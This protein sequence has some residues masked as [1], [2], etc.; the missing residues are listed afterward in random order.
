MKKIVFMLVVTFMGILPHTLVAKQETSQSPEKPKLSAKQLKAMV[1]P[2]TKDQIKKGIN[3][4][5]RRKQPKGIPA[6]QFR[7]VKEINTYRFLCGVDSNMVIDPTLVTQA[8]AAALACKNAGKLSHGLGDY[9]DRCNLH[10]NTGPEAL[11]SQ[12]FNYMRDIGAHN[13]EK[14]GHRKHILDPVLMATGFSKNGHYAAMSVN[15]R[16]GTNTMTQGWGYPGRGYFPVKWFET[17]GWSYYPANG[18][19]C[20]K[21]QTTVKMW[22]LK[23]S[24]RLPFTNDP[25]PK[26]GSPIKINAIFPTG[27]ALAFEPQ[28]EARGIYWIQIIVRGEIID[29]YVVE[30]Y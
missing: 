27:D 6:D 20:P 16:T 13:R 19:S 9:T 5:E 24:P 2:L 4:I 17:D 18:K 15:G 29:Q 12:I 26:D 14:R 21:D 11:N 8:E 3:E 28:A 7:C 1:Y 10:M 22:K 30:F 25:T 23:K